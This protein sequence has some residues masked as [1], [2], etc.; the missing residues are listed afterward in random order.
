MIKLSELYDK[1]TTVPKEDKP[2][3][4]GTDNDNKK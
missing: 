2:E 4:N 1:V 3:D